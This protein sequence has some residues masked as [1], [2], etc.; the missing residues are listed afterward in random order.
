MG[1]REF[2]VEMETSHDFR[3][4]LIQILREVD[5]ETYRVRVLNVDEKTKLVFE[6]MPQLIDQQPDIET[7][8]SYWDRCVMGLFTIINSFIVYKL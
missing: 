5:F 7:F 3:A 2:V 6:N 4:H 8:S 1:F